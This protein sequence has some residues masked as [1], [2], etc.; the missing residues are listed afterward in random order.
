[1]KNY[2]LGWVYAL[3]AEVSGMPQNDIFF[4]HFLTTFS[5]VG[6]KDDLF[7]EN[8]YLPSPDLIYFNINCTHNFETFRPG[9]CTQLS[10]DFLLCASI[11]I[12]RNSYFSKK[13]HFN[14]K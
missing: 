5:K 7:K 10:V 1:M 14:R 13:T 3:M 8:N 4:G 9:F 2:G 12:R 11:F 6:P